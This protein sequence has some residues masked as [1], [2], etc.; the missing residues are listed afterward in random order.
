M[1]L[2]NGSMP[3]HIWSSGHW[4]LFP[5]RVAGST[6]SFDAPRAFFE[7]VKPGCL[8]HLLLPCLCVY[9]RE[10]LPSALLSGCF[11]GHAYPF[12]C[13]PATNGAFAVLPLGIYR[14]FYQEN[15][16]IPADDLV[17]HDTD[18]SG[19]RP[20]YRFRCQYILGQDHHLSDHRWYRGRTEL[21]KSPNRSAEPCAGKCHQVRAL[22]AHVSLE[23]ARRAGLHPRPQYGCR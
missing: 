7:A 6:V 4:H 9:Q 13:I 2:C 14:C 10:L 18:D 16:A 3:H 19:L 15:R 12:G 17:R 21:P 22:A 20:L 23:H 1:G 5:H 11:G 8:V